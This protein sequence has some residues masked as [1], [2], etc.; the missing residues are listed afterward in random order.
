MR[1]IHRFLAL[2]LV[3][4]FL[5]MASGF[6]ESHAQRRRQPARSTFTGTALFVVSGE[7]DAADKEYGM[8]ALALF[9]KGKYV[10]P[11]GDRMK[12]FAEKYFQVGRQYRLLFGGGE[13][14]T[15]KVQKFGEGCNVIHS[16]V[17]VEGINK[18]GGRIYALATDSETLGKRASSRRALTAEEREAVMTLVKSIYRQHQTSNALMRSLKVGNL[19]A[20]DLNG[21]GKFEVVG[22][23]QIVAN[24][25]STNSARRDLFLIA[26]PSGTGFRAELAKFQSYRMVDGFGSGIAFA[27]QLDIDGDGVAEVVTVNEGYDGYGYSIYKKQGGV[28]R[29]IYTVTGDAC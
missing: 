3:V 28:W 15:V 10:V 9:D 12:P 19:T 22:D 29:M 11:T 25:K 27:D 16:N 13:V 1:T 20:T 5:L 2:A 7:G 23:F 6:T 4:S 21:D 8:D 17:N 26:T 14:G 18:V 24:P